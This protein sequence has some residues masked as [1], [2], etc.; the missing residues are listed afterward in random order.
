MKLPVRLVLALAAITAITA[1]APA[2]AQES[3]GILQVGQG[4]VMTS[5]GGEFAS[6][7][8]GMPLHAGDRIMISEGGNATVRFA[9]G[10]VVNYTQPGVYTVEMPTF[11]GGGGV[12]GG[13]GGM[14]GSGGGSAAGS[15]GLILGLAGLGAAAA[16]Q[17]GDDN[18]KVPD[19][20]VSR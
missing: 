5:T 3:I 17:M 12:G 14:V 13:G 4:T 19:R 20:P 15:A 1:I 6:A 7:S 18:N 11:A 2:F 9:D 10:T 8:D 16:D